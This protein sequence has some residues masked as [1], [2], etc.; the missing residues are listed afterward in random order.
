M[1][2]SPSLRIDFI[3]LYVTGLLT[4]YGLLAIYAS[5]ALKS[6]ELYH[7]AHYFFQKQALAVL[8]GFFIIFLLYKIPFA[9]ISHLA[10]PI[11]LLSLILLGLVFVPGLYPKVGGAMRWLDIGGLRIQPG[12]L[13]KLAT[14][15]FLAK[16]L[17]REKSDL[18]RFTS[19][20]LP[21]ILFIALVC[22][23]LII[24]PDFGTAVLLMLVAFLM[25]F[26]AGLSRKTILFS[27]AIGFTVL[28][29]GIFAAPYR[30]KRLL[31]FLDPWSTLHTEGFQIIQSFLA[32]Q[33]GGMMGVGV[34]ASKQKLFFLPEAHTDFILSVIAEESGFLGTAFVILSFL[35]LVVCGI[36]T[37]LQQNIRYRQVL[38]FGFTSLI[39]LQSLFNIG[40][41]MGVLPTKGI[42]LPLI[43]SGIASLLV[44][45]FVI[46][47]I[48][49]LA[50]ESNLDEQR[51]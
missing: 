3:I 32:F 16:N 29:A 45:L 36:Q 4:V 2:S 5:S 1:K 21:N 34:G 19:G 7:Q 23:L 6:L 9:W 39:A 48:A 31:S 11:V 46:G 50:K 38:S 13:A 47:I 49:R 8:I 42:P 43:S 12:E 37:T 35:L 33:N 22:S 44:F 18:N 15:F 24:Q 30:V 25:L 17:S 28:T 26:I 14:V 20:L 27:F 51:R 10:L 40:V 41:V